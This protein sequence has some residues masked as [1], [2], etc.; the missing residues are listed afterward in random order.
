MF[1]ILFLAILFIGAPA[2]SQELTVNNVGLDNNSFSNL[3][4]IECMLTPYSAIG[5]RLNV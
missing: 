2:N 4:A 1:R 3:V 5:K